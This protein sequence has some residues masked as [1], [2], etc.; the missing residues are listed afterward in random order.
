ME[1]SG[2]VGEKVVNRPR[3]LGG[4]RKRAEG[5]GDEE[6]DA[7]LSI[8]AGVKKTLVNYTSLLNFS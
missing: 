4:K 7:L 8:S 6:K 5:D 3:D 2:K 1:T